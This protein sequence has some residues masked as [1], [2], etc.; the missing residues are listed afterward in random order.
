MTNRATNHDDEQSGNTPAVSHFEEFKGYDS[1]CNSTDHSSSG[2][3]AVPTK[4]ISL[5]R[6]REIAPTMSMRD[7]DVLAAVRHCRY[8]TTKQIQRLYFTDAAT[9]T[10]GLRVANRNM[11]KLKDLGMVDALARRIGGVRAGSGSLIWYLTQAGERLLRLDDDGA[12][13]IKRFFEPSPHFLAHTLAVSECYVQITE[14]CDGHKLK[15]VS[16]ELE[17]DCWRPFSHKGS[18]TSL[19]PDLFAVTRC[20]DYEDRWSFE[21]DLKTE[22][23]VT[24]VEKCR[25]YHQ[26]YRSGLEQKQHN[27]FPLTVWVVPDMARKDSITEHIRTEFTHSPKLFIVITPDELESLIR[28]GVEGGRLC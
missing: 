22:A 28:Q 17:T 13:A 3:D 14:I 20:D 5:K 8:L 4:R 24:V 25:R 1:Y 21:V 15:L 2:G 6:L 7:K 12:H 11:N 16:A 18:Q 10:A 19:K 26:Y 23:P 9:P 27:V